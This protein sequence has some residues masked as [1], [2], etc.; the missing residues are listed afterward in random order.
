M[1]L[2]L[3][4]NLAE[5]EEKIDIKQSV[6]SEQEAVKQS[7][8]DK[9][10]TISNIETGA[11][12]KQLY[13]DRINFREAY[14]DFE[15][16]SID[17][18]YRNPLYGKV[19]R[20]GLVAGIKNTPLQEDMLRKLLE[21]HGKSKGNNKEPECGDDKK[22]GWSKKD[23]PIIAS[24][25]DLLGEPGQETIPLFI[26]S[27]L[28][29]V[30]KLFQNRYKPKDS[31]IKQIKIVKGYNKRDQAFQ[32][33]LD[34][35]YNSF[36]ETELSF[37]AND[38]IIKDIDSFYNIFKRYITNTDL[39]VT[40]AGFMESRLSTPY[41]SGLVYDLFDGDITSDQ[42]KIKFYEDPNFELFKYAL[43]MHGFKIDPNIPWRAIADVTS[44]KMWPYISVWQLPKYVGTTFDKVEI[45]GIFSKLFIPFA[46]YD[47]F[48]EN[49]TSFINTITDMYNVFISQNPEYV[50]IIANKPTFIKREPPNKLLEKKWIRWYA[51]IRNIEK[52]SPVGSKKLKR[53][54]NKAHHIYLAGLPDNKY[55]IS[56]AIEYIEYALGPIA[57]KAAKI[58]KSLTIR[59]ESIILIPDLLEF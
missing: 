10:G 29:D 3:E 32:N 28:V 43:N 18:W 30:E 46:N 22:D 16:N 39:R 27:A 51:E 34:Q 21:I 55:L 41:S 13:Q 26:V 59:E 20:H 15:T 14:N 19:S 52:S 38:P 24:L 42:E 31:L 48:K 57:L 54:A 25:R 9:F 2:E 56:M 45:E 44:D 53:I 1:T 23:S 6:V 40:T 8:I 58:N 4:F 36:T 7:I 47:N 5:L 11:S 35:I 17:T 50:K 49:N 33:N 12:A 37:Y